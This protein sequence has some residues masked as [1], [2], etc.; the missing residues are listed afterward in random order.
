MPLNNSYV[1]LTLIH[2][3]KGKGDP[4]KSVSVG[5]SVQIHECCGHWGEPLVLADV[6][7]RRGG[8]AWLLAWRCEGQGAGEAKITMDDGH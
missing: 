2:H 7:G 8:P 5:T 4:F 1:L 6:L 3:P